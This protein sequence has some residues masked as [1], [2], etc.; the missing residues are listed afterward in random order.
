[1][2]PAVC[3][4]SAFRVCYAPRWTAAC[5][6]HGLL[7][8]GQRR[9]PGTRPCH[10]VIPD[11]VH[12]PGGPGLGLGGQGRDTARGGGGRPPLS[13]RKPSAPGSHPCGGSPSTP[14]SR[15]LNGVSAGGS[16]SGT[17]PGAGHSADVRLV[18]AFTSTSSWGR[19]AAPLAPLMPMC[20]WPVLWTVPAQRLSPG[21]HRLRG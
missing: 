18:L 19:Q 3:T 20:A 9:G 12:W 8:R 13:C 6:E 5:G 21:T 14:T 15:V 17:A 11:P 2:A 1:M 16:A 4:Q 7:P 10:L